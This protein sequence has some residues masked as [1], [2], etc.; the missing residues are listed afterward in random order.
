MDGVLRVVPATGEFAVDIPGSH[1]RIHVIDKVVSLSGEVRYDYREES[2]YYKPLLKEKQTTLRN[3]SHGSSMRNIPD[4]RS[5]DGR[6]L[7][8]YRDSKPWSP[9]Y[10][11]RG[12]W[13]L[14]DASC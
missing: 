8:G 11:S 4:M 7:G 10:V 14:R 3:H 13:S 2:L 1:E 5:Q 9:I 6:R 12:R